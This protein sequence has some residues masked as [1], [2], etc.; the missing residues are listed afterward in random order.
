MLA[1]H[2]TLLVLLAGISGA[3]A[4]ELGPISRHMILHI[5]TMGV[6]APLAAI[7]FMYLERGRQGGKAKSRL[8]TA[9]VLQLVAF[10]LW[11]TPAFMAAA[12][13]DLSVTLAMQ[14]T[15]LAVS[16]NFWIQ[17]LR[18]NR[19]KP[20]LCAASLMVSGKVF[21]LLAAVMLFAPQP[22]FHG[23]HI[24]VAATSLHDQQ[25][26]GLIMLA[27]CPLIYVIS[28]IVLIA[29]WFLASCRLNASPLGVS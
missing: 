8:L 13:R 29:R 17:V 1:F 28:G 12:M 27:V 24:G 15:L 25:T 5:V 7:L 16:L 10:V 23:G 3:A 26:A 11:H 14:V 2:L 18:M 19:R 21:C 6:L 20:W 9:T 22:A 4:Q